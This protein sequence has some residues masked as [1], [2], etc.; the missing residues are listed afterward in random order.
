MR[1]A[2][3]AGPWGGPGPRARGARL[4]EMPGV[5]VCVLGAGGRGCGTA[6]VL[7]NM[8]PQQQRPSRTLSTFVASVHPPD[9]TPT[10]S[11]CEFTQWEWFALAR[12]SGAPPQE[13]KT[14]ALEILQN[15]LTLFP[16]PAP[17]NPTPLP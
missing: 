2:R 14:C 8:L 12:S 3:P 15:P 17:P 1:R 5:C 10:S 7:H 16:L 4:F 13:S 6:V 11:Q 9:K